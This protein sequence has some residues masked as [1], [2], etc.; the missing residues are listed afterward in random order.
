MLKS[1]S[2]PAAGDQMATYEIQCGDIDGRF[3][4]ES[5]GAAYRQLLARAKQPLCLG[6]LARFRQVD[7]GRTRHTMK[8]RYQTPE[9]LERSE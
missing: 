1:Y 7:E 3:T 6:A 8:W 2:R 5:P 9:C 4:A